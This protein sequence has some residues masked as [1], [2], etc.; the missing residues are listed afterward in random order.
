[1]KECKLNLHNSK[2]V[3]I[4]YKVKTTAP[5]RYNVRPNAGVLHPGE[6][7]VVDGKKN[8]LVKGCSETKIP[9]TL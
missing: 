4:S 3:P 5:K 2:T 1:V 6:S 9:G 8:N 7:V